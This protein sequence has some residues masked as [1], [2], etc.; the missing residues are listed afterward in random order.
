MFYDKHYYYSCRYASSDKWNTSDFRPKRVSLRGYIKV[1]GSGVSACKKIGWPDANKCYR[2]Q[3]R[4]DST[5]GIHKKML[6]FT[7]AASRLNSKVCLFFT[8]A[9]T[10]YARC[11]LVKHKT[12]NRMVITWRVY[13]RLSKIIK[14]L[15]FFYCVGNGKLF[16]IK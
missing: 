2:Y 6:L 8:W 10:A 7:L 11:S 14:K 15:I 1:V 16:V 4:K 5:T 12:P 9:V 13:P 3:F